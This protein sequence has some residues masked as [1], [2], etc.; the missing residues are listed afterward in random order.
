MRSGAR[1]EIGLSMLLL[2]SSQT[3]RNRSRVRHGTLTSRLHR[4]GRNP[5]GEEAG[6][7]VN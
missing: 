1:Q 7:Y 5:G 3:R 4:F 6:V 2:L